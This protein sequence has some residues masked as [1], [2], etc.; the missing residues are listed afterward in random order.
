MNGAPWSNYV[1]LG[2]LTIWQGF[3]KK[4]CNFNKLVYL[5]GCK[6]KT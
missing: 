1:P 2:K 5:C 4:G 3:V 6:N